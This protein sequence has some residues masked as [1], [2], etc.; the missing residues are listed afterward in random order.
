[1]DGNVSNSRL[2]SRRRVGQF[3]RSPFAYF[4]TL[5]YAKLNRASLEIFFLHGAFSAMKIR[6]SCL[7]IAFSLGLI[8]CGGLNYGKP[9]KVSG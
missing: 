7:L 9:L 4:D 6:F 8:G 2:E 1:M 3:G 5:V